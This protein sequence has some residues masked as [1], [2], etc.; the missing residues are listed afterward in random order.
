MAKRV[1]VPLDHS[2][3]AEAVVPLIR[4]AAR[5]AG[6]TVRLLSVAPVPDNVLSREGHVVAYADQEMSRIT[7]ERL[8]YLRA[9]ESQF[10]GLAVDSVVRF[11]EP[12]V[13]ILSEA[14]AF[15]ADLI[16]VTTRTRSSL[17][18]RLLGSVAE[19]VLQRAPVAVMLVR[20]SPGSTGG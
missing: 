9:V 10:E 20:P 8:D 18:R 14:E 1:L 7:G 13:E 2:L 19:A 15:G 3:E 16:A 4:D 17:G 5:G 12:V 6:A 11:G